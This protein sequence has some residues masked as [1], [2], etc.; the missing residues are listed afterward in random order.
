MRCV[1]PNIPSTLES[2]TE[3]LHKQESLLG[4]IHFEMNAGFISKEKEDELWGVQRNIT[5]LKVLEQNPDKF[6]SFTCQ[7]I[8]YNLL[9][10]AYREN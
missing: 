6:T 9:D 2:V 1:S 3:E 5:H 4:Q 10:G 8:C 7:I